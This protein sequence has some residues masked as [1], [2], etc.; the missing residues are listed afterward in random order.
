[1]AYSGDSPS[2][3]DLWSSQDREVSQPEAREDAKIEF[4][5][6]QLHA[7]NRRRNELFNQSVMADSA[8]DIMLTALIARE[9]GTALTR[10]AAAMANRLGISAADQ[11]IEDLI[12]ARLLQRGE[13]RDHISMT[14]MGAELMRQFV[15]SAPL[16]RGG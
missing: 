15:V 8:M 14:H 1:M 16:G 6:A 2:R 12:A 7:A 3:Q 4:R 13:R 11:I 10:T 5:A 9:Q